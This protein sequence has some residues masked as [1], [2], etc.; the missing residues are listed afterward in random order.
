M[1]Q[2]QEL[3]LRFFITLLKRRK[4]LI[5]F[6]TI[7]F[8]VATAV[9]VYFKVPFYK[10]S[11]TLQLS[12]GD[13][14][15]NGND[16]ILQALNI[17]PT[18]S[19]D[20]EIIIMQSRSLIADVLK[21][22]NFTKRVYKIKNFK[23]VEIPY[24]SAPFKV[25]VIKGN[26]FSFIIK[27]LSQNRF[28]LSAKI[29]GN[30]FEGEYSF[31]SIIKT[32]LFEVKLIKV[33]PF[34]LSAKYRF[35]KLSIIDEANALKGSLSVRRVNP[36]A[37]V[38]KVEFS[39]NIPQRAAKFVNT[40]SNIYIQRSVK[41]KTM[42]ADQTLKF[43]DSQLAKISKALAESELKLE[44]FKQKNKIADITTEAQNILTKL[45]ELESK[46]NEL[47]L[48][49]NTIN[50]ILSQINSNK[51][52]FLS[53]DLIDDA[54]LS[55]LITQLQTLILKKQEL[56]IEYTPKHPAVIQVNNQIKT[57]KEMIRNRIKALKIAIEKK[58][59]F[60]QK[61]L[62]TYEKMLSNI[63]A[64]ER[65][66][67]DLQRNYEVNQK[68]YS[69]LLEKRAATSIAKAGIVSDNRIIDPA[70]VPKYPYKPKKKVILAVGIV[71]GL[72]VGIAIA[73]LLELLDT[74]IK[75]VEDV[76]NTTDVPVIGTVPHFKKTDKILKIFDSPKSA[77]A[78]AFRAIRTNIRFLAPKATEVI[79][80]TSTISGEGKTTV[81]S[82]LASIYSLANKK[83]VIVNLDM[84]KPTLHKVFEISNDKGLSQLLVDEISIDEA[85]HKTK[86]SNLD[87]I[88]SGP[89][90]PNP[91]ELI[92]SEKMHSLIEELKKRY[93][94][95]IFD[96]PPVG[97]VVDAIDVL[98]KSDVNIYIFRANYSKKEFI[99]VVNDL[100]NKNIKGLGI[101]LNDIKSTHGSY[102]GYGYG[103]GY[104]TKD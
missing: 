29:N 43:I 70:L 55:N 27:P 73:I 68:I 102:Y 22:V 6:I 30:D 37:S 51:A 99:K 34:D 13:Q 97:V 96:T 77:I 60:L 39:D 79:S 101:I 46:L 87:V 49:E 56:L 28:L 44:K 100:K 12:T 95:V 90:P 8:A 25:D 17:N 82:N 41:L 54:A 64:N 57:I 19:I 32:P 104:Y 1:N 69:Y 52:K 98:E 33:A 81:A 94:I 26:N 15:S 31:G 75:S 9:F 59:E 72:I 71:L 83:T 21:H 66:L 42:Q 16:M 35:T 53:A 24:S 18:N 93:E 38:V 58:K 63:P 4:W 47:T 2:M 3:D 36:K 78:E 65:K 80:V 10:T 45:N 89:I 84:R 91:G 62:Q 40:L 61:T 85:I 5:L 50:F 74:K 67:I 23:A 20:T 14:N 86:H 92:Q 103:Y 48:K 76:E 7:I 88:P 11:A